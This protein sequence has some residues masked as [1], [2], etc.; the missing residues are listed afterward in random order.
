MSRT[1][2]GRDAL[3]SSKAH[4]Q[5]RSIAPSWPKWSQR[6]VPIGRHRPKS[7]ET[8][9]A[10]PSS[11][12][13]LRHMRPRGQTLPGLTTAVGANRRHQNAGVFL[14]IDVRQPLQIATAKVA[15]GSASGRKP[16]PTGRA[17][18]PGADSFLDE[19][20]PG[21]DL[22]AGPT[23]TGCNLRE[24][25]WQAERRSSSTQR[26]RLQRDQWDIIF[27]VVKT[28]ALIPSRHRKAT[29]D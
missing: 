7:P 24:A 6:R 4:P 16:A 23:P 3:R 28:A 25:N 1:K 29:P 19:N 21:V 8:G 2:E 20:A 27:F 22:V 13:D 9:E 5:A 17:G 11:G 26:R 12:A 15:G 10:H 14:A 18:I